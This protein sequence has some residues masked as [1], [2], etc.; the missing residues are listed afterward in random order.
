VGE[1]LYFLS[2]Y[3]NSHTTFAHFKPTLFVK[4]SGSITAMCQ[5]RGLASIPFD[6]L[7]CQF[8]FGGRSRQDA[9]A[10]AY[11][12]FREDVVH[13]F[14]QCEAN[15][16]LH[17]LLLYTIIVTKK[18]SCLEIVYNEFRLVPELFVKVRT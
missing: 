17:F 15:T 12:F 10:I 4:Y 5:Y 13:F 14:F 11:R 7:G 9:N 18:S 3:L 6:T 8:I 2:I 1:I 16:L